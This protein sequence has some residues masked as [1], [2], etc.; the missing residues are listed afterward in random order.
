VAH[1]FSVTITDEE[2]RAFE[3]RVDNPDTWVADAV[4]NKVRQS[5]N[6]VAEESSKPGMLD[7]VDEQ[8]VS[9][10]LIQEGAVLKAPKDYPDIVKQEIAKRINLP[11]KVDRDLAELPKL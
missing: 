4:A 5:L 9:D 3:R 11:T 2:Y 10:L 8:A 1:T 7:D 6:F